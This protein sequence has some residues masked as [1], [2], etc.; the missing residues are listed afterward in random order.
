MINQT[1]NIISRHEFKDNVTHQSQLSKWNIQ[2]NNNKPCHKDDEHG[3]AMKDPLDYPSEPSLFIK[4]LPP[5]FPA[6]QTRNT[7]NKIIP[8]YQK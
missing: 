4:N 7:I 1:Q 3:P 5:N 8:V 6:I 2:I